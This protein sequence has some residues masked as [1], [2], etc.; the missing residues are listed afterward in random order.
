M[1]MHEG[2]M[3]TVC[4]LHYFSSVFKVEDSPSMKV[5]VPDGTDERES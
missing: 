4:L 2:N 1:T 5:S 3:I